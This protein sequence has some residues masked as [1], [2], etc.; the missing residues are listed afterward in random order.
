MVDQNLQ[1]TLEK[2]QTSLKKLTAQPL[3]PEAQLIA[4]QAYRQTGELAEF[5]KSKMEQD[6]LAALYR[7]S[8]TLGNSLDLDQVLA[9][10]LDAVIELTGAE[11]GFVVL[12]EADGRKLYLRSGRDLAHK[13]LSDDEMEVSTTVIRTVIESGQGVV[14]TDA[15]SDPR[16]S[17]QTSVVFY[18]L[19]SIMCAPLRARG[20][21]IGV[22][23]VD[24][25]VQAGIF[26]DASLEL[27]S[28]FAAQAA[29]AIE[30]ARLYTRTDQ[31]LAQRV[32]ELEMLS[33]IDAELNASLDLE[34]VLEITVRRALQATGAAH[35]W[36]ALTGMENPELVVMTGSQKERVLPPDDPMVSA[37]MQATFPL[38]F[39]AEGETPLRLA[40]PL[41]HSGNFIGLLVVECP[42]SCHEADLKFLE[43]LSCR[44]ASAIQNARLFQSVQQAHTAKS[45][46]I[47]VVTHEIRIPMTAIKGY[48][49]LIRSGAVGPLN[50][51][52]VNFL[53]T[54]RNN[55]ER[56]SV[57][58]SDLSDINY[59]ESGRL[60]LQLA[61]L[62][63]R[64]YVDE[65]V[66]SLRPKLDE[67]RHVVTIEVPADLQV[68]ADPQR[69]V[70]VLNNLISNANKYTPDGGQLTIRAWP[71]GAL[72]RVEVTDTG[73][74]I[75]VEDQTRLF[76]QFFRSE[77]PA[78][79]E[80]QGWGL[81]LN[82]AKKLVELMGG[83]IGAQSVLKEGST[84]W[85]TLP[86]PSAPAA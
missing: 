79:R 75:S 7:V 49:D 84:F 68:Y 77:D 74:G 22:I 42:Q 12:S 18:A 31:A 11:R 73:I 21:V 78:V 65:A 1:A 37:C 28:A 70:Q 62:L 66:N 33:E 8:Q 72:V 48:T 57:L 60:R 6:R 76:T 35:G 46:F 4:Q 10:V 58:V 26:S 85:F 53:N 43:R 13:T 52:Q 44:A 86:Q 67:R 14:S 40:T 29:I 39:P 83:E 81:G 54:I 61:D 24:N 3:P 71:T 25:R 50:E 27:L 51:M 41:Q 5:I 36:V 34:S 80:Q 16:F 23:Y 47:S 63:L 45:K 55:V 56:M 69:L 32:A 2:L 15:Q 59:M 20:E 38:V 19:R 82:V 64:D 30:N 17:A 9:Q